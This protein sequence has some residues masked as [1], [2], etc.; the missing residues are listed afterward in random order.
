MSG[1][2]SETGSWGCDIIKAWVEGMRG[3]TVCISAKTCMR[4]AVVMRVT[5][6]SELRRRFHHIRHGDA[7]IWDY[8]KF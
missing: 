2:L 3:S 6:F 7:L 8:S 5:V 1:I 4:D